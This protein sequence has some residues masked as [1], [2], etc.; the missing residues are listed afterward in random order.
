MA[1]ALIDLDTL[2]ILTKIEDD[3]R[4]SIYNPNNFARIKIGKKI[5][6][7]LYKESIWIFKDK[8]ISKK[9]LE[10][11]FLLVELLDFDKGEFVKIN[12]MPANLSQIAF[13]FSIT[14]KTLKKHIRVLESKELLKTIKMGRS[15]YIMINPYVINFGKTHTEESLRIFANSKWANPLKKKVRRTNDVKSN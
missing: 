13:L 7:R 3:E 11:F 5:F 15:K 10:I 8:E 2:E 6:Y 9:D 12:G 4:V 14:P 1:R